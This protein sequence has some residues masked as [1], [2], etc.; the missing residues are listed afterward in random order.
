MFPSR[1]GGL[2]APSSLQKPW[3][4]CLKATRIDGRFT[5]HGLRRTFVD[6]AR[7]ARVDSVVTRSLTGH[8]TEKMR[9]HYSTVGMDEKRSAVVAIA[10]LVQPGGDRWRI[11]TAGRYQALRSGLTSRT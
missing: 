11:T 5:I 10:A 2:R 4:A 1:T 9:I 7:R 3:L 6:L 8:V